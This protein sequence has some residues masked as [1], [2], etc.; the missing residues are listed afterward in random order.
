VEFRELRRKTVE[1]F[2]PLDLCKVDFLVKI[3]PNTQCFYWNKR[4][5]FLEV[6]SG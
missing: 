5:C 6:K 3:P 4:R 2:L 1:E